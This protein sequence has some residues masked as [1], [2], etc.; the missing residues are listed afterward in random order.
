M[1]YLPKEEYTYMDLA[2]TMSEK[3]MASVLYAG[4]ETSAAFTTLWN[5]NSGEYS[6]KQN[7]RNGAHIKV[8]IHPS[9]IEEFN[10][11]SGLTLNKPQ[12][13]HGN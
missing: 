2:I 4:I 11:L 3:Q 6:R 9:Q 7:L 13:I 12:I 1:K 8:Y 5:M 10:K